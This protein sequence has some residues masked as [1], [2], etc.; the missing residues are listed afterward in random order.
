MPNPNLDPGDLITYHLNGVPP[1]TT[2]STIYIGMVVRAMTTAEVADVQDGSG[3]PMPLESPALWVLP[4]WRSHPLSGPEGRS[5]GQSYTDIDIVELSNVLTVIK[6]SGNSDPFAG[7][8][9]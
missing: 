4:F 5:S 6:A 1:A 2:N 3:I 9:I 7:M 8:L